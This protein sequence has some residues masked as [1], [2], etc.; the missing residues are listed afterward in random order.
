VPMLFRP[1]RFVS[2]VVLALAATAAA[3]LAAT[4][5]AGPIDGNPPYRP[6][7]LIERMDLDWSTYRHEAQGSDNWPTTWAADGNVYTSWGDGGGF[8]G[9]NTLSRVSL[10][11][12]RTEGPFDNY[13]VFNVWGGHNAASPSSFGGKSYG[14]IS[15]G[16][17]L[18]MWVGP[19][20][21]TES[22]E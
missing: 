7:D 21:N 3:G 13:Q 19:G 18:Y 14:I 20:S 8:G 5:A 2:A 12:A 11:I 6:S 15:I 22:Y 9:S 16:G 4:V 1:A 10:G 17:V